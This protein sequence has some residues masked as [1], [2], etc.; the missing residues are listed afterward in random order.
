[1]VPRKC[2]T[3][4]ITEYSDM[5]NDFGV[6]VPISQEVGRDHNIP[7]KKAFYRSAWEGLFVE[8]FSFEGSIMLLFVWVTFNRN[9][10]DSSQFLLF[11]LSPGEVGSV[12]VQQ[13]E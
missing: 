9:L 13:V 10:L 8:C 12:V 7:N 5:K 3:K 2:A 11:Y 1:M 4:A 6:V